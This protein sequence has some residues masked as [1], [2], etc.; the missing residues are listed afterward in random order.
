M[1]ENRL[2]QPS[3][4]SRRC[5]RR[6]RVLPEIIGPA[7]IAADGDV[8][9]DTKRGPRM[10]V[11]TLTGWR[12]WLSYLYGRCRI[13]PDVYSGKIGRHSAGAYLC[14]CRVTRFDAYRITRRRRRAGRH[15][16]LCRLHGVVSTVQRSFCV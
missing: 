3:R 9:R 5:P 12:P 1:L 11:R 15:G 14:G 16:R 7:V 13:S 6:G 2:R 4:H 10:R 8:I